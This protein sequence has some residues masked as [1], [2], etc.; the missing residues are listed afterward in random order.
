MHGHTYIKYHNSVSLFHLQHLAFTV[1]SAKT[2]V[3]HTAI[4]LLLL[5][6]HFPLLFPPFWVTTFILTCLYSKT[7]LHTHPEDGHSVLF[8]N[9]SVTSNNTRCRNPEHQNPYMH[10][11]NLKTYNELNCFCLV[12][13][14][15]MN[16]KNIKT[17]HE[18]MSRWQHSQAWI[19]LYQIKCKTTF[20]KKKT[21][22]RLLFREFTC[23]SGHRCFKN[24]Q[25][26]REGEAAVVG[27]AL[28]EATCQSN[29]PY[30]TG[31]Y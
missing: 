21:W 29:I 4:L 20:K 15:Q 16:S 22:G 1:I 30:T 28:E 27:H 25:Q 17:D 2:A 8:W 7:W 13:Y 26:V 6:I 11:E 9:F 19:L 18:D 3:S 5:L 24:P 31:L 14:V 12:T 10:H 23:W